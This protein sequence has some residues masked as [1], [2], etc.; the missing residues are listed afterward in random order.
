[1]EFLLCHYLVWSFS[2]TPH[3]YQLHV[4]HLRFLSAINLLMITYQSHLVQNVCA[5]NIAHAGHVV[6]DFLFSHKKMSV[7]IFL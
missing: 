6:V 7:L 4:I 1:M 3:Y 5:C 2:D